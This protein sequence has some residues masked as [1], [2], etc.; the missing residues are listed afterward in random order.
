MSG[1]RFKVRVV[2]F[3]AWSLRF[4]VGVVGFRD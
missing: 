2:G 4:R 1:L 3:G